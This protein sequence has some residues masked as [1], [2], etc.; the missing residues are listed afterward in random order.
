[1]GGGGFAG[2]SR[3]AR[4]PTIAPPAVAHRPAAPLAVG[5]PDRLATLPVGK[6]RFCLFCLNQQRDLANISVSKGSVSMLVEELV[7]LANRICG[8]K[9]EEQT[10]EVKSEQNGFRGRARKLRRI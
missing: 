5:P 4:R 10:T 7:E 9:A 6:K 3:E 1:M 2:G 8:Q